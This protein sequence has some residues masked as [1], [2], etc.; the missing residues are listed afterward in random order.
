M[1]AACGNR[2]C[3][4]VAAAVVAKVLAVGAAVALIVADIASIVP[5]VTPIGAHVLA[6]V[7]DVARIFPGVAFVGLDVGAHFGGI[8]L[9]AG[10]QVL[11]YFPALF[12]YVGLI[13]VH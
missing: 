2:C 13:V 10:F 12:V 4:S 7:V 9:I 1:P 3:C 8:G 6:V 5:D 11:L